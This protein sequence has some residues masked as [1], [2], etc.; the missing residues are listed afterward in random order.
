MAS[1]SRRSKCMPRAA[2]ASGSCGSARRSSSD[3][4]S[5]RV[6]TASSPT[7]AACQRL[8]DLRVRP[9]RAHLLPQDQVVAHAGT[10]G[11]P[12]T[13]DV[14]AA[15]GLVVEVQVPVVPGAATCALEDVDGPERTPQVARPEAQVLVE[16]GPVLPVEV[17]VEQLS[18]PHRLG[19]ALRE[20]QPGH[21]LVP[22]LGI[23]AD[24]VGLLQ[25]VDERD[26]MTDGGQQDV[27]PR[28]VRLG[29]QREPDVVAL[30]ADVAAEEVHR[31]LVA[32]QRGVHV[33]GATGLRALP[34][35]PQDVRLRAELGGE[36][37]VAQHLGQRVAADVAVVG[38]QPAVLEDGVAE[39]VGRGHLHAQAGLGQRLGEAGQLLL[40]GG[41]VGHQVVVVEGDGRG[42]ELGEPVHGLDRVQ[43]RADGAAEDVDALP[44]HRPEAEAEPVVAGRGEVHEGISVQVLELPALRSTASSTRWTC[45]P[46]AKDG[47]GSSPLAMAVTRSTTWWVK[48][49]S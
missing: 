2:I 21:L 3:S 25:V 24:P 32:V 35:A 49:C 18:V 20:V 29:L 19:D 41:L 17:D 34:A 44:S 11:L 46:S 47:V 31:L 8:G 30:V 48:P 14:L 40:P 33:L 4:P 6:G 12:D 42:T 23:E 27:A 1:W 15:R 13:V 7:R 16:A 22:D 28:L 9:E 5:P 43:P 10:G 37:E 36:V 39:Q 45:S 26:R 38:G